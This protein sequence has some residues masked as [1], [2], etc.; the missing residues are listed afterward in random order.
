V[1][2]PRVKRYGPSDSVAWTCR[3]TTDHEDPLYRPGRRRVERMRWNGKT[4]TADPEDTSATQRLRA[5]SGR[6]RSRCIPRAPAATD[7]GAVMLP[8]LREAIEPCGG[9]RPRG[10]C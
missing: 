10:S 9:R 8:V 4:W 6:A 2:N 1:A 7:R 3:S 5:R